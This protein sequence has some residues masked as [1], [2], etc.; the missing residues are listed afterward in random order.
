MPTLGGVG[1]SDM[2]DIGV[3]IIKMNLINSHMLKT[4]YTGIYTMDSLFLGT[5]SMY[6]IPFPLSLESRVHK[7]L[8]KF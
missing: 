1:A 4:F 3:G 2:I 5:V 8:D 7:L 6:L